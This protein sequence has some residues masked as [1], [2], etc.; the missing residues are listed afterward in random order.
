MAGTRPHAPQRPFRA[1]LSSG[2]LEQDSL[3]RQARRIAEFARECL[4]QS[5]DNLIRIDPAACAN[6]VDQS[7]TV[8][9]RSR[10]G[11]DVRNLLFPGQNGYPEIDKAGVTQ[12]I[13]NRVDFVVTRPDPIELRR[14]GREKLGGDF[15]SDAGMPVVAAVPDA[16]YIAGRRA[17]ARD[18]PRGRISPCR[19]RTER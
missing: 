9:Q 1:G 15:V 8:D 11:A 5:V 10:K 4:A 14:I 13:L 19:G 17:P 7:V 6:H 3:Q 18:T 16:E 12:R 2:R